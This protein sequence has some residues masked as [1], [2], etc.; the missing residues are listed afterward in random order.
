MTNEDRLKKVKAE[1][2]KIKTELT[3]KESEEKKLK[4][5]C[6]AEFGITNNQNITVR[7][8]KIAVEIDKLEKLENSLLTEAE[9]RIEQY[10][11]ED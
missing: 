8:N 3:I 10:V 7:L 9:E 11:A 2:E 6:K 4:A 1:G 5:E